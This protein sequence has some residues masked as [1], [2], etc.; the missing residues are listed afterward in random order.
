MFGIKN[1]SAA[2][3]RRE[4]RATWDG[5]DSFRVIGRKAD[6]RVSKRYNSA[7][8]RQFLFFGCGKIF[9]L[10]PRTRLC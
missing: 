2:G 6:L 5:K 7:E 10:T 4:K 3:T 1:G 8:L 9:T